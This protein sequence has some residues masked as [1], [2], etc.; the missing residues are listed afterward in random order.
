MDAF[1]LRANCYRHFKFIPSRT[2]G[3]MSWILKRHVLDIQEFD[4]F[5]HAKFGDYEKNGFSMET[6]I[7]KEYGKE[8]LAFAREAF[9]LEETTNK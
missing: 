2:D 7:E 6:L 9:G 8:S 3:I 4:S 5:L 1:K